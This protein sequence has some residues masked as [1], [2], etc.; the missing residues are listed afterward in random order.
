MTIAHGSERRR[1][2]RVIPDRNEALSVDI[3]GSNFIDIL[4]VLDISE[5]G[6]GVRVPHGFSGCDLNQPISFVLTLPK[7]KPLYLQGY[8]RIQHISG[9]RF[10]IAF[11]KLPEKVSLQI[12]DYV[13]SHVKEESLIMWIKYKMGLVA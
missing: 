10:G 13:S 12:R 8:G 7:D 9:D 5:G 3:N 1:Y 6:V 11:E 4:R 2:L